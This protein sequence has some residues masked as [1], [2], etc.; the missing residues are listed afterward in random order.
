MF[1]SIPSASLLGADGYAVSVQVHCGPGLPGFTM[2]GQ[3]D[4]ACRE[5]RDRVR[6]AMLGVGQSWPSRRITVNLAPTG[7]R[8]AG[9]SLDLA[10][11]VA[12]L[13]ASEVFS[14]SAIEGLAFVGELGLDGSVR[15]VPGI[16]PMVAAIRAPEVVVPRAA[17]HEACLLG[18]AKMRPIAH[19]RELI[20]IFGS[21]EARGKLADGPP[22]PPSGWPPAPPHDPPVEEPARVDLADVRGQLVARRALEIAAA[23]G[24][25]LLMIGP[26]GAGKTMLARRLPTLLPPLDTATALDTTRVHSAAG[27]SLPRSGLVRTPPFRAPHHTASA[28]AVVGGGGSWLRPG[29]ISLAH[30][31]VLFLDELA[32]FAQD[33]LESL[34]QP[35][36]DG[37]VSVVRAQ[38]RVVFPA[39]FLLV[40][41]MNPCPCGA[42]G[43]PGS[44]RCAPAALARYS[45]R[46]SA[47][48]LDR[49]DLCL[50]V[51]RPEPGQ[52]LAGTPGEGSALV[53]ARVAAARARA[54]GR[55]LRANVE[56]RG[57][58]LERTAPLDPAATA[59]V[60][61]RLRAGQL[62]GRGLERI[63]RVALTIADLEGHEG[64][65]TAEQVGEALVL[66]TPPSFLRDRVAS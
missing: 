24:H 56:L 1:A 22:P 43:A 59:V 23:G 51:G 29:E 53:A 47:P 18:R 50:E 17:Y 33:V 4:A 63:R 46:L 41:A 52:L 36:E 35:L 15:P 3:P 61:A 39:S 58:A 25:H 44:C 8:K 28:V 27:L 54:E 2:I 11:A 64:P 10:M 7:R 45:R 32:E 30:G 48:L 66:R 49:F 31:G 20:E 26:P 13:V 55:G 65:L 42:E 38:Y 5:A 9:S 40:G 21:D 14:A 34:R 60:E 12:L 62:T 6:S 16:L 37:F 19:L 57:A